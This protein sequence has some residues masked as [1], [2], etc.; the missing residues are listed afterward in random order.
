MLDHKHNEGVTQRYAIYDFDMIHYFRQALTDMGVQGFNPIIDN[1]LNECYPIITK[2][3]YGYQRPRP[4]QL[5]A[6]Y[7]IPLYPYK[8]HSV[9]SPSFPSGHAF[10]GKIV[11]EVIGLKFPETY[12]IMQGISTDFNNSRQFMG[13]HYKSDVEAGITAAICILTSRDFIIKYKL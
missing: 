3:K 11:C 7:D 2:L 8:S 10:M 6:Y 5:A 13:L 12:G 4:Y 9:D 1:I